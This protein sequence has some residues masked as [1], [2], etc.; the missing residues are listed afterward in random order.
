MAVGT[1]AEIRASEAV[2]EAYLGS[3]AVAFGNGRDKVCALINIDMGAVGD[4]A[5]RRN[6]AY[7]GYADLAGKAEVI[8]LIRECVEKVNA[9]LVHDPVGVEIDERELLAHDHGIVVGRHTGAR[10]GGE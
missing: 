10:G 1:P 4:W 8:A 3:A 9:E 5:E 6:I 7:S 2:Q